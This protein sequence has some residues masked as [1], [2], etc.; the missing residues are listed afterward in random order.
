MEQLEFDAKKEGDTNGSKRDLGILTL[1]G[2][3]KR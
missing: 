2:C 1:Y 3:G